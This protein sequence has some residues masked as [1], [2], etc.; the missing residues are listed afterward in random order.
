MHHSILIAS[1]L[2]P[3]LIA[4]STSEYLNFKIWENT[5][6]TL[7]YLNGLFLLTGGLIIIRLH[8]VWTPAWPMLITIVGWLCFFAG[9]F[10]MFFPTQKQLPLNYVSKIVMLTLF[11]IGIFLSYKG[12][13]YT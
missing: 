11:M 6:P 10:R 1:I 2:G 4:L 12:Y 7:V 9:L 13:F 5:H 8:N 3:V